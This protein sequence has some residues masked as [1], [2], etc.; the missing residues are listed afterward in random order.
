MPPRFFDYSATH[1]AFLMRAAAGRGAATITAP[2][3]DDPTPDSVFSRSLHGC[4]VHTFVQQSQHLSRLVSRW[5]CADD[6]GGRVGISISTTAPKKKSLLCF[7]STR[8]ATSQC[9]VL[10]EVDPKPRRK[11]FEVLFLLLLAL[12]HS[13]SLG[14]YPSCAVV[15]DVR[16]ARLWVLPLLAC[17]RDQS[18]QPPEHA[19]IWLLL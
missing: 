19:S 18:S 1:T 14:C 10:C 9:M 8:Q 12:F 15:P 6:V 17:T 3:E 7:S 2:L 4:T 11:M 13:L 16:W 5:H